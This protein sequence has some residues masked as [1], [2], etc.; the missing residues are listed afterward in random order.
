MDKKIFVD[1]TKFDFNKLSF[2]KPV[3][4]GDGEK[5][6]IDILYDG[7]KIKIKTPKMQIPFEIKKFNSYYKISLS[8]YKK[9]E[10]PLLTSFYDF[11]EKLD[12]HI[13]QFITTK[14]SLKNKKYYPCIQNNNTNYPEFISIKM[15]HNWKLDEK[16]IE[17]AEFAFKIYDEDAKEINVSNLKLFSYVISLIELDTFWVSTTQCGTSW[18]ILQVKKVHSPFKIFEECILDDSDDPI[19][20]REHHRVQVSHTAPPP[21]PQ[22]L[23]RPPPLPSQ[24][25]PIGNKK[26]TSFK[27]PTPE[28]L[29]EMI[30]KMKKTEKKEEEVVSDKKKKVAK[31]EVKE[32]IISDKKKKVAK[33]EVKEE[34]ISKK[35]KK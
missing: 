7:K 20:V 25:P 26:P 32:E 2:S 34:V 27:P 29:Q 14:K 19:S 30:K 28:E 33:E 23:S 15:P 13:R 1:Y 16:T 6:K 18:H 11:L 12:E 8:F 3:I 22:T 10:S 24:P 35:K 21:P 5:K 4:Y 17:G 9:N 31:E